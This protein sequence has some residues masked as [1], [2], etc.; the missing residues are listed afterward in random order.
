MTIQNGNSWRAYRDIAEKF[1]G[2][3][4][5]FC[6]QIIRFLLP[7]VLA[8]GVTWF[9]W[10]LEWQDLLQAHSV[11]G[12]EPSSVGGQEPSSVGGQEPSSVGGQDPSIVVFRWL[13]RLPTTT[14]LY[15]CIA[16]LAGI[17]L[18]SHW[19][20]Y[21]NLCTKFATERQN[22]DKYSL[23]SRD[24][25]VVQGL[26][27]R[28]FFLRARAVWIL[29]SIFLLLVVG[30]YFTIF[31]L[32]RVGGSDE[33]IRRELR[34]QQY[35]DEIGGE[36]R[37]LS[38][39]RTWIKVRGIPEG[40]R[41]AVD[42][43]RKDAH[44]GRIDANV[45]HD[46]SVI[47]AE[48]EKE[49]STSELGVSLQSDE[50]ITAAAFS[51][52]GSIG[53]VAG[54]RGSVF[55]TANGGESWESLDY[56]RLER[57]EWINAA[58]F[59]ADGGTGVV[60]G[61]GGSVFRTANGGESWES[62]DYLQLER[63]ERITA[64]AFSADGSIGLVAGRRGSV[65]RTANGGE[66]WESLDY[67]RLERGEWITAA[68]FSADGGT[69]VVAGRRGSVF[70]TANGGESWESLDYLQ[71]ERGERITAAAFSADGSIGLVA[72]DEG[73]VFRT[74]NGGESWE[75]L[76]YLQ[77]ERGE[78]ITA[79]AFSADGS[80]GLVA[81]DEGSVFRTVNGGESWESLDLPLER[82][83]RIIAVTF[84]KDTQ[85][86]IYHVTSTVE[87]SIADEKK[88]FDV[89]I[90]WREWITAA[91]FS[92]DGG[93]GVVAGNEG[94]AFRTMDGGESWES[95]A[96][97]QLESGDR[98]NAA[99]FSADGGTGVVAGRRGS[100]FRTT[101]GGESWEPTEWEPTE[102]EG[103]IFP[104]NIFALEKKNDVSSDVM[105]LLEADDSVQYFLKGHEKLNN[106]RD[107][108]LV[109]I[110][111][112][113]EDDDILKNA[114]IFQNIGQVLYETGSVG[115]ETGEDDKGFFGIL[116]NSLTM[117]RTV[118]LVSL[119]VL[120]HILVRLHRYSVR[121]AAFW[122]ARAD[123]VLLAQSFAR[124]KAETFDDLAAVFAPDAYDFKPAPRLGHESATKLLRQ[125][126]RGEHRTF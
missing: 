116:D 60:A 56:L 6:I 105:F 14:M 12:Q 77:L 86:M 15:Y 81:G 35:R 42:E 58:A 52:D 109:E 89:P 91:A 93:I 24:W 92:A 61:R 4:G 83:E 3:A 18:G 37:S 21:A 90:E 7:I 34:Q 122:D 44:N 107:M 113:M 120:V 66:S 43:G 73:S 87:L 85:I 101:D 106:W 126:L 78:R 32:P 98:I 38:E 79:A 55:R 46:I 125:V 111:N 80:I 95:L 13:E 29:G 17:Y 70:R 48:H 40:L 76:D 104:E 1:F 36:L 68:A 9:F 10:P 50:W 63:G 123:A 16:A 57:G 64:A 2:N 99:A 84:S 41:T 102:I 11:G 53:L 26:R 96:Y 30:V 82:R 115:A 114:G 100:A 59:S 45:S 39:G 8:L 103:S 47:K 33:S 28:A 88:N 97:L 65:F 71:L 94:S 54:R 31:I 108:S 25:W 74:A 20:S 75:S 23:T 110:Y 51:A 22:D 72:G 117:M 121:L 118:T 27:K 5:R 112:T 124:Y 49:N 119:F 67:L 19:C 69:G 62:L